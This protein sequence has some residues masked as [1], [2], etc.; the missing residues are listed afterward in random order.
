[1]ERMPATVLDAEHVAALV[2]QVHAELQPPPRTPGPCG[3]GRPLRRLVDL[4]CGSGYVLRW[5]SHDPSLA[6]DHACT[7]GTP[8]AS[9]GG[10]SHQMLQES[11]LCTPIDDRDL[12]PTSGGGFRCRFRLFT[13]RAADHLMG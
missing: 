9:A 1:M 7:K 8:R 12:G 11:L 13:R 2:R 3:R 10:I 5:L 6:G 4:G